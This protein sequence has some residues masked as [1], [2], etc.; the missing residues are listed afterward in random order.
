MRSPHAHRIGFALASVLSASVL[1]G[2]GASRDSAEPEESFTR[3]T[4]G[5]T[6]RLSVDP[7]AV[8]RLGI[9]SEIVSADAA[10]G[11]GVEGIPA[12]ALLYAPDGS[13]FVYTRGDATTFGRHPVSVQRME[14][15][16]AWVRDGPPPGSAV[17]T[18]GAAEL[19]GM[20]FGL[21]DE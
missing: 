3:T 6:V 5:G 8:E 18:Q 14:G 20:E 21:E 11:G 10:S 15:G 19:T 13:T 1:G 4:D 9:Q 7:E 12:A 16:Y 2:C 17:V